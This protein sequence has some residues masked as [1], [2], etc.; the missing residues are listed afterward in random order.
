MILNVDLSTRL[1]AQYARLRIWISELDERLSLRYGDR[2]DKI[3]QQLNGANNWYKKTKSEA[4]SSNTI[5]LEQK[6]EKAMGQF[7]KAGAA[8][9]RKEVVVKNRLKELWHTITNT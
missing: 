6:Q 4:Q 8:T 9:A 1:Q 3:K 5:P 7:A 2:Y